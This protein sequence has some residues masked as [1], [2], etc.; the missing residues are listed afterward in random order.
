MKYFVILKFL[1]KILMNEVANDQDFTKLAGGLKMMRRL[2][3]IEYNK[4]IN[5]IN[6]AVSSDLKNLK[7][8]KNL[9]LSFK[10]GAHNFYW[11]LIECYN[12]SRVL[13]LASKF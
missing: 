13:D 3:N 5:L 7:E 8:R 12:Q 4:F 1:Y 9:K 2:G 6:Y 11:L 10:T